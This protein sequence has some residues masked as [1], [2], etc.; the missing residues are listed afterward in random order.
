M[1]QNLKDLEKLLKLLRKQGVVSFRL[2][3][4]DLKLGDLPTATKSNDFLEDGQ[5]NDPYANF[6]DGMLT[7]EQL[8]FYSAGGLP[9]DDPE[10]PANQQ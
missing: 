4:I 8:M 10:N 6:P 9:E 3:D 5:E 7:P 2:G 1:V